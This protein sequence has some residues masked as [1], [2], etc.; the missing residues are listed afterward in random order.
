MT[1]L[2]QIVAVEKGV[3]AESQRVLTEAYHTAQ[4]GTKFQG[5]SREYT[6]KDDEGDLLPP[7]LTLVQ[8]SGEDLLD[9]VG[10]ALARMWDVVATKDTTN[11]FAAAH[12]VVNGETIAT[13]VPV[14]TLLWL[15]KQLVDIGTF[16]SKLP[17]LDPGKTWHWSAD[18][19]TYMS[20][21]TETV[22][23]HKVLRNHVKAEATAHHPAQVDTY[24]EDVVAGTWRTTH[25]SGAFPAARKADLLNRVAT[26]QKAVKFAREEANVSDVTDKKIGDALVEFI[27]SA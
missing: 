23:T 24:T 19:G 1:R 22:K 15:E 2:N 11:C 25:M 7:E 9:T 17:T 12:I 13:A 27:F 6:P 20:D 21:P 18:T 8:Q 4:T 26:L 16:I 10:A 3:K 14:T 5:I